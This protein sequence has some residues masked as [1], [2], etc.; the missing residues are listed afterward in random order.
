[1]SKIVVKQV[2][3]NTQARRENMGLRAPGCDQSLEC[4]T[5][6]SERGIGG[7]NTKPEK[8]SKRGQGFHLSNDF[9]SLWQD[10]G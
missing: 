9:K 4:L 3:E 2:I 8:I 10:M 7:Q 1:M 5:G 6:G